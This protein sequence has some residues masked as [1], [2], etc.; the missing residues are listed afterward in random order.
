GSPVKD[1]YISDLESAND[2]NTVQ[3]MKASIMR[4]SALSL[5]LACNSKSILEGDQ[6]G[7]RGVAVQRNVTERG[8]IEQPRD[9]S[10]VVFELAAADQ[11][12]IKLGGERIFL[13][14]DPATPDLSYYHFG[15][16]DV[17]FPRSRTDIAFR[18]SGLESWNNGD[19]L[20]IVSPNAGM[21]MA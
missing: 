15:R 14:A 2:L 21:T 16:G 3:R 10:A 5:M 8:V 19:S 9:L 17:Q 4:F 13:P 1:V 18:I 20:Q 6:D 7:V 12:E 11:L